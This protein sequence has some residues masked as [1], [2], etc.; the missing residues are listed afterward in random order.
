MNIAFLINDLETEAS[1][2][3]TPNLALKAYERGHKVFLFGVGDLAYT[4]EGHMSAHAK[5]IADKEYASADQLLKDLR[6]AES[7]RVS[8]VDLDVLFLR[9]NPAEDMGK[10]NWAQNAAYIFGQIAVK[11]NVI[12]LNHPDS[13]SNAINKMYFQHFPEVLRPKTIIT[14]QR[15]EIAEFYKAQNEKIILKPLKGSGGK[16]VFLVD[17][18]SEHNLPQIVEAINR[19]GYIIAQEYLPDAPKGDIRF[20][21]MNGDPLRLDS[22][23]Y[24]AIRRVNYSDSVRSNI[25]AGGQP[26]KVEV[27]D[28]LLKLAEILRPKLVQDGM[29]LVG[30]DVVGDKLMEINVFSPGGLNMMEECFGLDFMTQVI[31]ALEQKVRY[32]DIYGSGGLDN[33]R[34]ATL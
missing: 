17:E 16:N 26:E 15:E 14:R 24:A 21:L 1:N 13:L 22:G 11:D 18:N 28:R 31:K 12:V 29:F 2:Y 9:N 32:R 5:K 30:I 7:V 25:S 34:L 4:V 6:A 27:D 10:R 33:I 19:D 23:E 3:T 8:S 20:F